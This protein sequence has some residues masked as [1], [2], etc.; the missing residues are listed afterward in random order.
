MG[1]S[2]VIGGAGALFFYVIFG[3][4]NGTGLPPIDNCWPCVR[5][6]A[7]MYIFALL[8]PVGVNMCLLAVGPSD[9]NFIRVLCWIGDVL[10]VVC[11][12]GGCLA[13]VSIAVAPGNLV[14]K[15]FM[16]LLFFPIFVVVI[17]AQ[18]WQAVVVRIDLLL[19]SFALFIVV[20]IILPV[21]IP[22]LT[23]PYDD[24]VDAMQKLQEAFIA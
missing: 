8:F 14:L 21:R 15:G 17:I 10:I 22:V 6:A 4:V 13:C 2:L 16:L 11:V 7:A 20:I 5:L 12:N 19:S 18:W 9:A 24:V 3:A 23:P 1:W